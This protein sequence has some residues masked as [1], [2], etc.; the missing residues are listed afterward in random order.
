MPMGTMELWESTILAWAW[1]RRVPTVESLR[2]TGSWVWALKTVG[3][4]SVSPV[5]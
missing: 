3:E 4:A 5:T 1:G 2:W